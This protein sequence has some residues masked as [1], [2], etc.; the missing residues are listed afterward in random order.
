MVF[1]ILNE[2]NITIKPIE[3]TII[4][5]YFIKVSYDY[6]SKF[7]FKWKC[8]VDNIFTNQQ[9]TY[10]KD[11]TLI[12]NIEKVNINYI[13]YLFEILKSYLN[14]RVIIKLIYKKEFIICHFNNNFHLDY[15]NNKVL[16]K[17][18][19]LYMVI[20]KIIDSELYFGV[21]LIS[22]NK[23]N[24]LSF[25]FY[26]NKNW[27]IFD[28]NHKIDYSLSDKYKI[29]R[30]IDCNNTNISKFRAI[31]L[32]YDENEYFNQLRNILNF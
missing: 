10:I 4:D 13:D 32:G 23:K 3:T 19:N 24:L 7:P 25:L 5:K 31:K 8:M 30:L 26:Y 28:G 22:K 27:Y 14:Y 17:S 6:L 21:Y 16:L 2:Q 20:S 1:I 29:I 12:I 15:F 18:I 9:I 11:T